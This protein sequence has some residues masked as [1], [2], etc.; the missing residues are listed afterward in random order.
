MKR[1]VRKKQEQD[2]E[3]EEVV[4]VVADKE[5]EKDKKPDIKMSPV[6][7]EQKPM[8]PLAAASP[9]KAEAKK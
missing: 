9:M 4:V 5:K 6:E 1:K 7:E 3:Q 2:K 8:T